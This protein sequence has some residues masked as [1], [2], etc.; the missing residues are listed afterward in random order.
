[1]RR[2][3]ALRLGARVRF[4]DR[5]SGSISAIEITE[6]WEAVNAV[7][8]GGFFLRRSSVR[9]P[10]S[11]ASDWTDNLVTFSCTSRQAFGHE[12]PPVAVP[13]RPIGSDT[14]VSTPSV[15]IAG[16]LVDQADRKVREIILS[17]GLAG[18]LRIAVA[19]VVFEGKTLALALQPETLP[20]YRADDDIALSI[21][22]VIREDNGLTAD[23]KRGLHF[24]VNSGAV[25]MSGNARVE[26]ARERAIE[27]VQAIS[28]VTG[29]SDASHDD[30]GLET[31]IGLVLDR[32][33]VGRHSQIYARSSLGNVQLYGYVPS[34]AAR[35]DAVRV[36]TAVPGVREITS[37]LEVQPAAA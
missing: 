36:A 24:A 6:D 21:Q 35:D 30:L 15:R 4:E 33:G 9:L 13:S 16:A 22:R 3:S 19:N 2:V 25:T 32:A 7:V 23:D 8:E 27:K 18:H 29:V 14:P 11:A 10:L 12:V 28:G 37:K 5:W 17:R 1:M 26:N 34:A 31:T 20:K